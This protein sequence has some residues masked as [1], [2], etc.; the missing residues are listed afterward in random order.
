MNEDQ[1]QLALRPN[2]KLAAGVDAISFESNRLVFDRPLTADETQRVLAFATQASDAAQWWAGDILAHICQHRSED[3]AR[4][5]AKSFSDPIG[6]WDAMR[7]CQ[8]LPERFENV[9]YKTHRS[10]LAEC[11]G[12]AIQAQEWLRKAQAYSWPPEVLRV[13]IRR[14]NAQLN[15]NEPEGKQA[16]T[17]TSVLRKLYDVASNVVEN[18]PVESWSIQECNAFMTEAEPLLELVEDVHSRWSYFSPELPGV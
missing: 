14:A 13:E 11:R 16:V 6:A 10:A 7:T 1:N 8:A 9:S 17:I 15:G 2:F 4:E 18:R 3:A 5:A 12:D